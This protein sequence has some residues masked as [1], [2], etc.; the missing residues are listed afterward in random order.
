MMGPMRMCCT[1]C[2]RAMPGDQ[3][4]LVCGMHPNR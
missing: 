1:E 2:P 4:L 3:E